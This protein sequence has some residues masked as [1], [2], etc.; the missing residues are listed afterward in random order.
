MSILLRTKYVMVET[1]YMPGVALPVLLAER[2]PHAEAEKLG[3]AVSAGFVRCDPTAEHGVV[4]EG[5]SE[6]LNLWPRPGDAR[7][8]SLWFGA[9]L[10]PTRELKTCAAGGS[11]DPA[12]PGTP[13]AEAASGAS[14]WA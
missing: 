13:C 11:A 9:L 3:R 1:A 8:I 12:R 4:T 2:M 14:L 5:H 7:M 6:G 10:S